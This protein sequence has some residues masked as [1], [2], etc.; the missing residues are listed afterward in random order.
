MIAVGA[1]AFD[2]RALKN[3]ET[4][5]ARLL[6]VAGTDVPVDDID[7]LTLPYKLGVNGY[8]FV[9]SNNGYVL[10]HPDLRP[11]FDNVTKENYNSVD[12]TEIE[13]YDD[14]RGPRDP[15]ELIIE[16]RNN[17][18]N[19]TTG[20]MLGVP[21]RF[22]YDKMRRISQ[23]LQD[24]YFA[25]LPN[26]PFSL[27]LVRLKSSGTLYNKYLN[28]PLFY[29]YCQLFMATHGLKLVTKSREIST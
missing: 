23:E 22:H 29:R 1:P 17:L 28:F 4:K 3:N 26:T 20:K 25:P 27:G 7:K 18:V 15:N 16:L 12:L 6:G 10:L 14:G 5:Q 11:V 21:I 9:V 2:R 13:Q 19:Y 24:Y 8:S